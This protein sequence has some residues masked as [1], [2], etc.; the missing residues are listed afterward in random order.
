M[1]F[2]WV[3][4]VTQ[5]REISFR[6]FKSIYTFT[7]THRLHEMKTRFIMFLFFY[8]FAKC[9][10]VS[11]FTHVRDY[12]SAFCLAF[13]RRMVVLNSPE[14]INELQRSM[15]TTVPYK[16]FISIPSFLKIVKYT[17]V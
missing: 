15:P 3:R 5:R 1:P 7:H 9:N 16:I 8:F 17:E 11:A 6:Q 12:C 2:Y 13:I 14:F 4:E 10:V